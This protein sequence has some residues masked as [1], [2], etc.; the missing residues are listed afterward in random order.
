MGKKFK[1]KRNKDKVISY[2]YVGRW[3]DGTLG[4]SCPSIVRGY[5]DR[6]LREKPEVQDFNE[7]QPHYLCK[8]TIELVKNKKGKHIM[9]RLKR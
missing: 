8:I 3:R 2:G 4:W 1:K 7:N 5:R 9:K 6:Q